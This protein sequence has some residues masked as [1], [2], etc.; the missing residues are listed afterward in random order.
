MEQGPEYFQPFHQPARKFFFQGFPLQPPPDTVDV[1]SVEKHQAA[2]LCAQPPRFANQLVAL[3]G[4]GAILFFLFAGHADRRERLVV[5]PNVSVQPLQRLE[6]TQLRQVNESLLQPLVEGAGAFTKTVA[7]IDST[8]LPAATNAY[9][10]TPWAT[11][12]P[13]GR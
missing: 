13:P 5:A 2:S 4:Q 11:T 12:P 1:K 6:L 3:A 8:D 9:K 7:L 10:K